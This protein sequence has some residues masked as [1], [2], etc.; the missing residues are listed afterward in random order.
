MFEALILGIVQGLTEFLPVS[1]TAHLILFPWFLNWGGVLDSLTFDIA[2]HAGTLCALLV[3]FWRDWLDILL[4][5][6]RLL[7]LIVLASVPA[8]ILGILFEKIV[9][10]K[11][12]SPLV[13]AISLA[14]IGLFLLASE[15]A[16]KHRKV[17]DIGLLD[18]IVIGLSQAVALIPGVSRSG[19]T[20]SSGIFMG[21]E[22][23]DAARFSFLLSTPVIGGAVLLHLKKML[24]GG[25]GHDLPL[26]AV[27]FVASA[28]TG[29]IAI[30]FLL[31]FLK[32][33]PVN[34][35]AYYRFVLAAVIMIGIWLK[36]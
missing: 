15:R 22:R 4:R 2:L 13:I 12:R 19:V 34:V 18:A 33:H 23:E 21:L 28:V 8:G 6:R 32:K 16:Y 11:L 10:S 27:G 9:E 3:C 24:A 29:L 1:S 36:G 20:I 30:K 35:F 17:D 25:E 14:V 5:K 26:F 7:L 31:N